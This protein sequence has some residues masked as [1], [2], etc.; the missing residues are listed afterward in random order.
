MHKNSVVR[1][2]KAAIDKQLSLNK[3]ISSTFK[4]VHCRAIDSETLCLQHFLLEQSKTTSTSPMCPVSTYTYIDVLDMN[5]DSKE[6]MLTSL[7]T[8]HKELRIGQDL[9]HLVVVTDATI[10]SYIFMTSEMSTQRNS[11]G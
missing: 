10:F 11:N 4:Y 2:E 6:A 1:C 9:K 7:A 5:A 3:F 8:L